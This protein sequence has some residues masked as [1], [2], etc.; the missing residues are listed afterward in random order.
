[1]TNITVP[2]NLSAEAA[3]QIQEVIEKDKQK[4]NQPKW[5]DLP[6]GTLFRMSG[7][8]SEKSS[9]QSEIYMKLFSFDNTPLH[10]RVSGPG[11]LGNIYHFVPTEFELVRGVLVLK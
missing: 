11:M 3:K 5:S 10:T 1:M 9:E 6:H 4:S 2:A 8:Y 7:K